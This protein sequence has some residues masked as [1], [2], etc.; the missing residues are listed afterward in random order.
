M[1]PK[2]Y[3]VVNPVFIFI[4]GKSQRDVEEELTN[5]LLVYNHALTLDMTREEAY[6]F[7]TD[8]F[9]SKMT[10]KKHP[11]GIAKSPT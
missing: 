11:G 4:V 3:L 2:N 8:C 6:N 10:S 5:V 9:K 1:T 7:T